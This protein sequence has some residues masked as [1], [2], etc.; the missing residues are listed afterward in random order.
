MQHGRQQP[1]SAIQHRTSPYPNGTPETMV[2]LML[3]MSLK[4][5]GLLLADMR[6]IYLVNTDYHLLA[7]LENVR[8]VYAPPSLF[9]RAR[10]PRLCLMQS[11]PELSCVLVG[12]QSG[13]VT[14]VRIL[15]SK[16]YHFR[17]LRDAILP[18]PV[19][20]EASHSQDK[21]FFVPSCSLVGLH[22]TRIVHGVVTLYRVYLVY[23]DGTFMGFELQRQRDGSLSS[24]EINEH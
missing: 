20:I 21:R 14:I 22:A 18:P 13:Y 8:P 24:L 11:L 15:R 19:S 2:P 4:N 1:F 3:P 10:T 9:Y 16:D 23:L 6:H 17:L 7:T 12:D 5:Q